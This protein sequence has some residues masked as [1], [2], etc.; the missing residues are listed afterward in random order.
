MQT[1]STDPDMPRTGRPAPGWLGVW[2]IVASALVWTSGATV[3]GALDDN[4]ASSPLDT[5]LRTELLA[6]VDDLPRLRSLLVSVDSQLVEEHYY[7]GASRRRLANIKSASKSII[8]LLVGIAIDRGYIR[9]VE[10]PIAEYFPNDLDGNLVPD[11]ATITVEDLLTMR[12]GLETTSNRNYGRFV[13]SANWVRHVLSRPMVDRPGGRRIYSTGNTHL[14]SAIITDATGMSTLEFGRRHLGEPLG[15]TLPGW[16]QDPQGIYFGGNEMQL[17]PRDMLKIGQLYLSAGSLDGTRV[18]SSEWVRKSFVPR[19]RSQRSGREYGY[20]WWMR[21][22]A[23]YRTYY[24]WGYGGQ[25]IFIVPDLDLVVT[26]T[27]SPNPGA[28]RREHLRA[29]HGV[30]EDQLIPAVIQGGSAL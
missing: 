5:D 15:F 2:L 16:L 10:Q 29:L 27:S 19:S 3:Q 6:R 26:M 14:L 25:F 13:Q 20:G 8:S 30:M 17:R 11:K 4:G 18:V 23:G 28:G 7:H 9:D 1:R 22:M 24:A 12:S 21:T